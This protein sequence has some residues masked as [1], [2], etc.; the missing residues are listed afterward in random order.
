MKRFIGI[1]TVFTMSSMA[2]A[3][4]FAGG[5]DNKTNNSAEY[6]RTGARN[7]ATD[8]A[9]AAIYNPA[10]T[11]L[12][13]DGLYINGSIQYLDKSYTNKIGGTEYE[14]DIPSVIPSFIALYKKNNWSAFFA[15]SNYGGGGKVE[16]DNGNATTVMFGPLLIAGANAMAGAPVFD[17]VSAQS[18]DADSMY[19]G[20]SAGG[21]Y[22]FNSVL[23]AS[24]GLRYIDA[25]KGAE[26]NVTV[27]SSG[28][29]ANDYSFDVDYEDTA[30]GVGAIF[31]L[32]IR[33]NDQWNIGIRYETATALEFERDTKIDDTGMFADGAKYD[34][35]L[36]AILAGG[37]SYMIN[38]KLRT[39][40]DLTL[41]LNDSADWDG[42]EDHVSTGYDAGFVFEYAFSPA[43][44]GSF[45]YL[46]T[47]SGISADETEWSAPRLDANTFSGGVA[48]MINDRFDLNAGISNV[49]YAEDTTSTGVTLDSSVFIV[50]CGLQYRFL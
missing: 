42:D 27:N 49:A 17:N 24:F 9:D 12:L 1:L 32:N 15:G 6:A 11:T 33:P 21:A 22:K 4:V 34:R 23:S 5:V 28:G 2:A 35:D 38:D 10:G 50:A 30:T 45:G 16:F 3:M 7:A 26:V 47:D 8:Y 14:S 25:N 31:G 43:I 37:V 13:Q 36:P 39:E 18:L 44:K 40:V 19:I 41:Y 20:L 48:W 29:F 46:R